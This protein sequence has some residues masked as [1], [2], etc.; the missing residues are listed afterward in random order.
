[1]CTLQRYSEITTSVEQLLWPIKTYQ[2]RCNDC[3]LEDKRKGSKSTVCCTDIEN[4]L[5]VLIY[6]IKNMYILTSDR[7][8]VTAPTN[9]LY[10]PTMISASQVAEGDEKADEADVV[11]EADGTDVVDEVIELI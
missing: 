3:R 5:I 2:V 1:M 10:A 4:R 8:S 6:A 9:T 11:E 7:A